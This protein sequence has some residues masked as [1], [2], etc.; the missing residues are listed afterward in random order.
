MMSRTNWICECGVGQ[1][2]GDVEQP[3]NDAGIP[4][5]GRVTRDQFLM[6]ADE[7]GVSQACANAL[8][9]DMDR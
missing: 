8:W 7:A 6:I 3:F 9:S 5:D 1:I 4:A 2:F